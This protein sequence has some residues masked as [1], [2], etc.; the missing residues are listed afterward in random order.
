MTR[1]ALTPLLFTGL[2]ALAGVA[3]AAAREPD[4]AAVK[5]SGSGDQASAKFHLQA[6]ISTWEIAHDGRSNFQ[7]ALLSKDGKS[8][9]TTV[10]EIGRYKG[11]I[12]VRVAKAGDYLLNVNADGK[13]SVAINQLRPAEA[14][15]TPLEAAGKG[16]SLT[17]FVTLPKGLCVFKATH[18]GDG[19]FRVKILDR[20]GRVVEQAVGV[21]GGYDG[22]KAIKIEEEGIYLVSIYANG[23]WTLKVE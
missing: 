14:P 11:T 6:G 12:A 22:S 21:I 23:E 19:V 2:L 13:W 9:D 16:T 5:L 15:A 1:Q 20:E 7:V 3:P 4:A 17:R 10:N 8:A 18:R